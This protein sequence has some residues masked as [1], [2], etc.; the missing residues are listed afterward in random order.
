[1]GERERETETEIEMERERER[2]QD[3]QIQSQETRATSG[4]KEGGTNRKK[5]RLQERVG[6]RET[7]DHGGR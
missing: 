1:M 6:G 4:E 2:E 3:S 7:Q 5:G